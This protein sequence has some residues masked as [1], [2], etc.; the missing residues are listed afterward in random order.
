MLPYISTKSASALSYLVLSST[1]AV[2]SVQTVSWSSRHLRTL[3]LHPPSF[4]SLIFQSKFS[5]LPSI[6]SY[7]HSSFLVQPLASCL[8]D[9]F[10]H[11]TVFPLFL[12]PFK[13]R[14][15][16]LW[17]PLLTALSLSSFIGLFQ[18][19]FRH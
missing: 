14:F 9:P 12:I 10:L 18:G 17:P 4:S 1:W 3:V 8:L 5:S 11:Q 2:T 13:P 16:G 6:L 19:D 15:H 7:F